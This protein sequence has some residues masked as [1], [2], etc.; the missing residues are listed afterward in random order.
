MRR[1]L[2]VQ[3]RIRS[4][5]YSQSLAASLLVAYPGITP[6][7]EHRAGAPCAGAEVRRLTA[8][9]IRGSPMQRCD[10]TPPAWRRWIVTV[11]LDKR[12]GPGSGQADNG[13]VTE[14]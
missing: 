8:P 5:V 3:A 11:A 9:R 12:N 13:P 14:L 10:Q 2:L 6:T 7:R 1:C 4:T